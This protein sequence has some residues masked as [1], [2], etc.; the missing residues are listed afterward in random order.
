MSLRP[1]L[2]LKVSLSRGGNSPAKDFGFHAH[3]VVHVSVH[4]KWGIVEQCLKKAGP[5]RDRLKLFKAHR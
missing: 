4:S 5:F 1:C 2:T 3:S